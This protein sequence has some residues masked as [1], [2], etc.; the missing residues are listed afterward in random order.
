MV[1]CVIILQSEKVV[2][3]HVVTVMFHLSTFHDFKGFRCLFYLRGH[4]TRVN[5]V[6]S[7][8]VVK[9]NTYNVHVS[10]VSAC[11]RWLIVRLY[12]NIGDSTADRSAVQEDWSWYE[13][14]K[15][16]GEFCLQSVIQLSSRNSRAK[17][18]SQ[19]NDLV[20]GM[21]ADLVFSYWVCYWIDEYVCW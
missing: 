15:S 3:L 11:V 2:P 21:E 14:H 20:Q 7:W 8:C 17:P 6:V 16:A 4:R 12:K 9:H 1:T 5:F 13:C 10:S 19:C 18:T